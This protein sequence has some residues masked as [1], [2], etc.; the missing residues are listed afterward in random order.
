M[1]TSISSWKKNKKRRILISSTEEVGCRFQPTIPTGRRKENILSG[2]KVTVSLRR[3]RQRGALFPQTNTNRG[4]YEK[5]K[6]RQQ[7]ETIFLLHYWKRPSLWPFRCSH[8]NSVI[9]QN[10]IW[11]SFSTGVMETLFVVAWKSCNVTHW[12]ELPPALRW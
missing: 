7:N 11:N 5:H 6:L 9:P 12:S 10:T 2:H 4:Y 1:Q 3:M 8:K